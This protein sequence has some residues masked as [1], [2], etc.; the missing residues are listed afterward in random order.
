MS[1]FI[2]KRYDIEVKIC[3]QGGHIKPGRREK[4]GIGLLF[5]NSAGKIA[6]SII[7]QLVHK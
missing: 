2:F 7:S 3:P 4:R 6:W 5:S 1:D